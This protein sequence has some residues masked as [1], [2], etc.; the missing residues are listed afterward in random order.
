MLVLLYQGRTRKKISEIL[1]VSPSTTQ[2][3]I[4]HIYQKMGIHKRDDLIDLIAER[5]R[6]R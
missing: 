3:H 1:V 5:E 2:G 6:K 4:N